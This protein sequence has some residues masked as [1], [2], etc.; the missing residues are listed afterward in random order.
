[1]E[2]YEAAF[3]DKA[4]GFALGG[5]RAVS[6]AL[7]GSD[8]HATLGGNCPF[9]GQ[10]RAGGDTGDGGGHTGGGG[11]GPQIPRDI[12]AP[13]IEED[14]LIGAQEDAGRFGGTTPTRGLRTISSPSPGLPGGTSDTSSTKI[15]R[16]PRPNK[17]GVN[18]DRFGPGGLDREITQRSDVVNDSI[19]SVLSETSY[20]RRIQT[21]INN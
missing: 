14:E 12:D 2:A 20:P 8:E 21:I 10:L 4:D 17:T 5:K 1:M 6:C 15:R 11:G 16:D 18:P 9:R 3:L 13:V 7:C 19:V